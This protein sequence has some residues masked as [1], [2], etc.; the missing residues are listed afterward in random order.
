MAKTLPASWTGVDPDNIRPGQW[1]QASVMQDILE[2]VHYAYAR[3]RHSAI[4]ID[5]EHQA[6]ADGLWQGDGSPVNSD[7][8]TKTERWNGYYDAG[9]IPDNNDQLSISVT[10]WAINTNGTIDVEII[11]Y[12]DDSVVDSV[13]LSILT[14]S[15][16]TEFS[17]QVAGSTL[18]G[19]TDYRIKV[20]LTC[21]AGGTDA[22]KLYRLYVG[23]DKYANA[24]ALP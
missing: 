7:K 17:G 11:D 18:D 6:G 2:N 20:Y 12:S 3:M 9:A 21:G 24:G 1:V 13:S 23:E 16:K 8:N 22:L 15:G 10:A 19:A 14:A 4:A 5:F